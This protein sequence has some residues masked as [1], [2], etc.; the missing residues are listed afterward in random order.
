ME[1]SDDVLPIPIEPGKRMTGKL[2]LPHP[3]E[4]LRGEFLVRLGLTAYALAEAVHV[5]RTRIE[6]LVHE[7]TPATADTALRLARCFGTTARFKSRDRVLGCSL[8]SGGSA[9]AHDMMAFASSSRS[10][11]R[12]RASAL[13]R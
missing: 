4:V 12:E 6:R 13:V 1:A 2:A 7:E 11:P 10:S 3:G 5:P 8:D 9:A